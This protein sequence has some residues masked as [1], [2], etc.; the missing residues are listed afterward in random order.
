MPPSQNGAVKTEKIRVLIIDDDEADQILVKEIL[1]GK[2]SLY[3]LRFANSLEAGIDLLAERVDVVLLDLFL[4]DSRSLETLKRIKPHLGSI[5]VIILSGLGDEHVAMDAIQNGAQD[6]LVNG[7]IDSDRLSRAIQYAIHRNTLSLEAKNAVLTDELTGLHN[8]EGFAVIADQYLKKAQR[9]KS[10]PVVCFAVLNDLERIRTDFGTA[11]GV[12]AIQTAAE[13]IQESFRS[14]DLVA[15]IGEDEFAMLTFA[16]GNGSA[17]VV[18]A[19]IKKNKKYYE[20]QFNRYRLSLSLCAV[21]FG[22]SEISTGRD[23]SAKAEEV[24]GQYKSKRNV[25]EFLDTD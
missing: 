9:E 15:R 12:R 1:S 5:P 22:L 25:Q 18:S 7:N 20:A 23:L 3:D 13:V 4:T 6:Y 11:E 2:K 8:K 21:Y 14:S 10:A 16:H 17:K 19:R 24:L